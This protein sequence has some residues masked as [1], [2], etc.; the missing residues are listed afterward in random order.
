MTDY[1][2]DLLE[3]AVGYGPVSKDE[4]GTLRLVGNEAFEEFVKLI[5]KECADLCMKEYRTMDGWGRTNGD[6]RCHD[7]ICETFDVESLWR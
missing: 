3:N 4:F 1:I 6:V 2:K 7:L 5:A